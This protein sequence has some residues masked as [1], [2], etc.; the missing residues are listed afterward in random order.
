[1]EPFSYFTDSVHYVLFGCSSYKFP[2][3]EGTILF[4]KN[5]YPHWIKG[6]SIEITDGACQG[7]KGMFCSW[8]GTRAIVRLADSRRISVSLDRT[9]RVL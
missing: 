8:S 1:M 6:K 5:L 3:Q 2:A 9:I 7:V 4:Y